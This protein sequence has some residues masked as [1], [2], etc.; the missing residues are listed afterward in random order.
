M[1]DHAD[2][3][4][5]RLVRNSFGSRPLEFLRVHVNRS[6]RFAQPKRCAY[7]DDARPHLPAAP[8]INRAGRA[9]RAIKSGDCASVKPQSVS[10]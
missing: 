6:R 7:R 8:I 4:A 3:T 1:A 5:V 10:A 9:A 2:P